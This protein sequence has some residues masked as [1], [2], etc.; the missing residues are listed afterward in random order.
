MAPLLQGQRALIGIVFGTLDFLI[1]VA[2]L[3]QPALLQCLERAEG[4]L[5]HVVHGATC[6][7]GTR[8]QLAHSRREFVLT[9]L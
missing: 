2:V 9:S 7:V 4:A 3:V 6:E 8:H 5:D 1:E